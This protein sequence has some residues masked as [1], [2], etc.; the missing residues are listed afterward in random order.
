MHQ[1]RRRVLRERLARMVEAAE[2]AED[3]NGI[4]LALSCLALLDQH[5][6]DSKGRCGWCRRLRRWW[7]RTQH[8]SVLPVLG[9]YLEQP[10][11]MLASRS[12]S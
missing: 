4:R 6:I 7:R 3:E 2:R 8:C 12:R 5:E 10:T 9:F 1:V 11:T